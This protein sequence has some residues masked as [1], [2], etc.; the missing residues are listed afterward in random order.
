MAE[1]IL[2]RIQG[3]RSAAYPQRY[4]RDEERRRQEKS[5][6]PEGILYLVN[7]FLIL[8]SRTTEG[9]PRSLFVGIASNSYIPLS[10]YFKSEHL[11]RRRHKKSISPKGMLSLVNFFLTLRL[12]TTKGTPHTKLRIGEALKVRKLKSS[13]VGNTKDFPVRIPC[14]PSDSPHRTSY[15]ALRTAFIVG[16]ASNHNI[17]L[18]WYLWNSTLQPF[19]MLR[20]GFG[21]LERNSSLPWKKRH[22]RLCT[23]S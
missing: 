6:S 9:T 14:F 2:C 22:L 20:R 21:N 23:A 19:E 4:V 12:W 13:K 17:P 10:S 11:K 15:F 18:S 1:T 7:F 16:I 5:F 3:A 8:C